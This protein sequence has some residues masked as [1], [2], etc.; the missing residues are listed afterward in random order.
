MQRRK[1]LKSIPV[2]ILPALLDGMP[3][4]AFGENPI[5]SAL[6]NSLTETDHVMVIVQLNGGNDGLNTVL[7]LD[8]YGNLAKARQNILIPEKD[9]L[10]LNGV[11]NQGLHPSM[12]AFQNMF[13]E[14]KLGIVQGVSYPNPNR[15]HFR[16]TDIYMTASDSDK[17]VNSGWV[18]RYLNYEYANYPAAYPN[19]T[20]P[21]PL[22]IQIGGTLSPTFQVMGINMGI[23][24]DNPSN[25]YDPNYTQ[26]TIPQTH[27]GKE[28]TYIR[29]VQRQTDKYADVVKAAYDKTKN[30]STKYSMTS[31]TA[32]SNL[33]GQLQKVA[34][35]IAGGL[36]TRIYMVN[37]G[38]WDTHQAE[39]N[40]GNYDIG[41]H[42]RLLKDLSKSIEG[43]IDDC[44]LLGVGDRVM[45]MTFSEFGRRVKS[46]GSGGT[47]HGTGEPMFIFGKRAK[48]G[49]VGESPIIP[50]TVGSDDNVA[51]Q[52]DFR[53]V[54][55]SMLQDWLCVP[56]DTLDDILLKNFQTLP[57]IKGGACIATDIHDMNA[58]SG[59]NLIMNY[60]NPF[61]E[62]TNIKYETTG[63]HTLIEVFDTEGRLVTTVMDDYMEAGKYTTY[64]NLGGMP[65]GH[66]YLRLQ[67]GSVQQVKLMVK[68]Q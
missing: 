66:Y 19:T 47:D 13:N 48:G 56:T 18:G 14:G 63:G 7:N 28:F 61:N 2:A 49:V 59:K 42:G 24:V 65:M 41:T 15:S 35:M 50:D 68:V 16:A 3:I 53:S 62:I 32:V 64:V 5:L 6:T 9:A 8:R 1:F 55:A 31:A 38:G 4:R 67:N 27:A 54:Y 33:S 37:I 11:T 17:M 46:N 45:G 52:Y 25:T 23:A 44:E 36:K 34:R 29:E 57:I 39:E 40:L 60:P 22:A 26:D 10:K 12:G 43:F 20:M 51:M 21:D 58:A 30:L